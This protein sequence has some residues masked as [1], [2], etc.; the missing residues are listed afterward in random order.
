MLFYPQSLISTL[1]VCLPNGFNAFLLQILTEDAATPA[2]GAQ[3]LAPTIAPRFHQPVPSRNLVMIDIHNS[4][5][6][7]MPSETAPCGKV[8]ASEPLEASAAWTRKVIQQ[9][10]RR[11]SLV[12]EQYNDARFMFV[13]G[14]NN[15]LLVSSKTQI[16]ILPAQHPD[17]FVYIYVCLISSHQITPDKLNLAN[18][19]SFLA[20]EASLL[21]SFTA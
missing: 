5:N 13:V 7:A 14:I 21:S 16:R 6:R 17:L 1:L 8:H 3:H 10:R 18:S 15:T 11:R 19:K 2:V 9:E 20:R 4:Y 12:V